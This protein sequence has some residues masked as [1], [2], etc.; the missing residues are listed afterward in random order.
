MGFGGPPDSRFPGD[1]GMSGRVVKNAPYSADVVTDSVQTLPDGNHIRQSATVKVYRDSEGRTR[2]EQS[3]NLNGLGGTSAAPQVV[4]INDPVA[5]VNYALSVR[6]KTGSKSPWTPG[7]RGRGPGG[8][9]HD[10]AADAQRPRRSNPEQNL[11]AESLGHQT[12]EGLAVEGRRVTMTIPA[13]QMGNEMPMQI[14][15][16]TWYSPDLQTMV[17]SRRS[18]PRSGETVTRVTNVNRGEPAHTLFEP[19]AD[20]KVTESEGRM[21]RPHSTKTPQQK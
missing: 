7:G 3:V 21:P 1:A 2:R 15:T 19:P 11:K 8:P 5:G 17:L 20:Y 4:F 16:E 10:A 13:G 12:M 14:V 6:D 18:D 9:P